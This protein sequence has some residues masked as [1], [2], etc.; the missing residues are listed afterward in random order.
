[1]RLLPTHVSAIMALQ[2]NVISMATLYE[3]WTLGQSDREAARARIS[4]LHTQDG[5]MFT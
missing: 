1:M 3:I 2:A 5:G 4:A